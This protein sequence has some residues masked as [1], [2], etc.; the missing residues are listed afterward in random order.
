MSNQWY[1]SLNNRLLERTKGFTPEV[2]M[3]VTQCLW[4]DRHPWEVIEVKDARHVTIRRLDAKRTDKNGFSEC[5]EYEYT[6]NEKNEVLHLYKTKRGKWV[7]RIGTRGVDSSY[8]WHFGRAEE[9]YD[10]TM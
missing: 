6:S 7:I 5:Q 10:F 9:Y 3:G 1:G 8:G 4:S 2:G